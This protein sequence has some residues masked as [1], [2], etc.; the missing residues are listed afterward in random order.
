MDV[1]VFTVLHAI[2]RFPLNIVPQI[3]TKK[4]IKNYRSFMKSSFME[5]SVILLESQV[6]NLNNA[7]TVIFDGQFK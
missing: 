7:E 5:I 6:E 4:E 2:Q 1:E 3:F